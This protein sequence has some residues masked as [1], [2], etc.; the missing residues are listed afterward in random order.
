MKNFLQKHYFKIFWT[1]LIIQVLFLYSPNIT[2]PL[3][4]DDYDWIAASKDR[5]PATFFVTNF[6]GDLEGGN[7]GP[8]VN[9]AYW[10]N[11]KIGELNP[12]P[13]HLTS[14]FFHIG[15]I[16]FVFLLTKKMV[17]R[18]TAYIATFLFSVYFNHAESV[19]WAAV[20]P[21]LGATFF[22]L[23][24]VYLALLWFEHKKKKLFAY[25]LLSFIISLLFKEIGVSLPFVVVLGAFLL[26][27]YRFDKK[28][29]YTYL[30]IFV[31]YFIPVLAYLLMRKYTTGVFFGNYANESLGVDFVQYI[32]NALSYIAALFTTD[33]A[34]SFSLRI[35][36][37]NFTVAL[38]VLIAAYALFLYVL[39][40]H[41][42]L[43]VVLTAIFMF[44]I[45]PY[46]PLQ[47]H[48]LNN[49]GERYLYLVSTFFVPVVTV[50][51]LQLYK[52]WKI[53]I[54][55]LL[56]VYLFSLNT[57]EQK[58]L[59]WAQAGY[60]AD[61]ILYDFGEQV[62]QPWILRGPQDA[63]EEG[64]V[65]LFLIDNYEGAEVWRNAIREGISLRYPDYPLDAIV[66]PV[67]LT[68]D[69]YNWDKDLVSWQKLGE[70]SRYVA[71]IYDENPLFTG[72]DR[73]ESDDLVYELWGY[74]YQYFITDTFFV[75]FKESLL[76]SAQ[77]KKIYFWYINEGELRE[78]EL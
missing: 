69:E 2:A 16:I 22:Y 78:L 26:N 14:L 7:Y 56:V 43:I 57:L 25:S 75:R 58:N 52:R 21:H 62:V 19:A 73:R 29:L 13:Y 18:Q 9:L 70:D 32:K 45:A 40:A 53:F 28:S 24:A 44:M 71:T 48:P 41:W 66:L 11:Y 74:D 60:L 6:K 38:T 15:V 8:L 59:H 39:K 54:V 67:Y 20:I 10:L 4:S 12:V 33:S 3:V 5:N 77:E 65:F 51:L 61:N 47:L 46:L 72:F 68:L 34:R 17:N 55:L 49:S 63:S 64:H 31:M 50:L 35:I 37:E 30:Q 27:S 23:L 36:E 1:I 42:K 76:R